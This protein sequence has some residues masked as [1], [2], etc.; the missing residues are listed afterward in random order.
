VS[1][2]PPDF[3]PFP[4]SETVGTVPLAPC[5]LLRSTRTDTRTVE[6]FALPGEPEKPFLTVTTDNPTP[7]KW[8]SVLR[9][10]FGRKVPSYEGTLEGV[11][12][13]ANVLT[14]DL[15]GDARPDFVIPHVLQKQGTDGED[16]LGAPEA[17]LLALSGKERYRFVL[18]RDV[19]FDEEGF[20]SLLN[21]GT[22]QWVHT[23]LLSKHPARSKYPERQVLFYLHRLFYV[24]GDQLT[25]GEGMDARFPK[26]VLYTPGTNRKNHKETRLLTA[27]QKTALLAANPAVLEEW[28]PKVTVPR[29]PAVRK[30]P[31]RKV[32]RSPV[33]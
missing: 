20:V 4:A 6:E 28:S 16:D 33:R 22:V 9:M 25:A 29:K 32:R 13:F 18:A 27:D 14:A 31:V 10:D 7:E 21:D 11:S 26:F 15:N 17:V 19:E 1:C 3:G 12:W 2:G 5:T 30:A 23:R 8:T 24:R